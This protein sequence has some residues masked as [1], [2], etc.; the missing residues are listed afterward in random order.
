MPWNSV[1]F[2]P[3]FGEP[4]ALTPIM[5][6]PVIPTVLKKSRRLILTTLIF[7]D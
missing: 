6:I 1:S 5:V 2:S 3:D 7:K 4:E